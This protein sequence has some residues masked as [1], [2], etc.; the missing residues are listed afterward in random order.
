MN[1]KK[2]LRGLIVALVGLF[3]LAACSSGAGASAPAASP[4]ESSSGQWSYTDDTGNYGV[5]DFAVGPGSV[6]HEPIADPGDPCIALIVVERPVVLTG[7]WGRWLNP[8]I[9]RG[10]I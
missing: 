9:R 10:W 1:L 2:N 3:T 8:L 5:G 6:R 7:P 4:S